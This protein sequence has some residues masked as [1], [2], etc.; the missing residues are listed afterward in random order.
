M[1]ASVSSGSRQTLRASGPPRSTERIRA[2]RRPAWLQPRATRRPASG[3][4]MRDRALS[5]LQTHGMPDPHACSR[6][7]ASARWPRRAAQR[8]RFPV[9]ATAVIRDEAGACACHRSATDHAG[10]DL[11][12]GFSD[13]PESWR[14]PSSRCGSRAGWWLDRVRPATPKAS[15]TSP[16]DPALI[17][18][19]AQAGQ[20]LRFRLR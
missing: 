17:A 10:P 15:V 18:A 1:A 16:R 19:A 12:K 3:R 4:Y 7:S 6:G 2:G 13:A 5:S 9:A 11:E 20:T 8:W 14:K